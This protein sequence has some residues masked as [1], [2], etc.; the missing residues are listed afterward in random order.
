MLN[1]SIKEIKIMEFKKLFLGRNFA[2]IIEVMFIILV[3]AT[4]F[5]S[6]SSILFSIKDGQELFFVTVISCFTFFKGFDIYRRKQLNIDSVD[7]FFF[8]FTLYCSCHYFNFSYYSTLYTGFWVFISY[9]LLFYLFRLLYSCQETKFGNFNKTIY[10]IWGFCFAQAIIGLMQEFEFLSSKNDYFDVVGTFINPNFLGVYMVM[11]LLAALYQVVFFVLKTW[12][13]KTV[14]FTSAF[15]MFYV[16]II[17]DSRASWLAFFIGIITLLG[18]SE[19][20]I[21]F[22]KNNIKKGILIMSFFCILLISSVYLLYLVN[23]ESVNGRFLIQKITLMK[24]EEKPIMG[25]GNFNFTGIYNN[26]KAIYFTDINRKWEEVR[27][28]NYITI[29]YNDYLQILFEIGIIGLVI[30]VLII[31]SVFKNM[32]FNRYARFGISI[33]VLHCFLALFTSVLYNLNAMI[34]VIWALAIVFSFSKENRKKKIVIANT[35]FNKILGTAVIISGVLISI[36][37]Y[38]K[39]KSLTSFNE[40]LTGENQK[41]YY[42]LNDRSIKCIQ[43]DAFVEFKIGFEKYREG[44]IKLG[45]DMMENSIKKCPIP[46]AVIAMAKVYAEVGNL[47][48][49]EELLKFSINIEPFRFQPR[50]ELL[51]FYIQTN[52]NIKKRKLAQEIIDLPVK[53]KSEKVDLYKENARKILI[54]Y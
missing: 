1:L 24:I 37:F 20:C 45:I 28:A 33:F 44:E 4:P 9:I 42:K 10:L 34:F 17:T 18:T 2:G 14:L 41:F 5:I 39:T 32:E 52:Q 46:D 7:V 29:C 13:Y 43:D 47:V 50:I 54:N 27:L 35:G 49:A 30:I 16:L 3:F 26:S 6:Y 8:I 51:Q 12:I 31:I 38:I 48:K 36:L 15:S 25:Y 21:L 53:I 40:V 19:S 23:K 11:G 22:F